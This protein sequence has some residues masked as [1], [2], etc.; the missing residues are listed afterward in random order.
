MRIL[1]VFT[2][3]TIGS[4]QRGEVISTDDEKKYKLI[5]AYKAKHSLDF[6]Y[7]LVEPYTELSENNTGWHIRMLIGCIRFSILRRQ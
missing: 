4:T 6:E 7:D 1:F 2:G 5:E 3:G